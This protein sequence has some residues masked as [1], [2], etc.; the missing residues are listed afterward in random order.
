MVMTN[1]DDGGASL[2]RLFIV[3]AV[4]LALPYTGNAMAQT[5]ADLVL[6]EAQRIEDR[7]NQRQTEREERFRTDQI[8]PPSG[9]E[10]APV[11]IGTDDNGQC[12]TVKE[13]IV[14]GLTLYPQTKF[15]TST[16]RLVGDCIGI[17]QIDDA[18]RDITN[19]YISDG[20][21]TSRAV[22]SPQELKTGKL[23]I[24]V[25][26]GELSAIQSNDDGYSDLALHMAFVGQAGQ[27]LNLR[28][29]EQGVDQLSR[30]NSY[31]PSI[32]I[33][34]GV[35]PGTSKLLVMRK[36]LGRSW[37]PTI[38]I[39]DDG[40]A[41]TGRY[42]ATAGL[43]LDNIAGI[44]DYWSLY[45]TRDLQRDPAIGNVSIGGFVSVPY[46]WWTLSL[47]GGQFRY[48]SILAGN[49]QSFSNTG[50]SWNASVSLDNMLYRD[51]DS[52]VSVNWSLALLDT[53]NSIQGIRLSSS[54]YR[55]VTG[56]VNLRWQQRLENS[57]LGLDLGM[58]RG[59]SILGANSADT[60]PGGASI[61]ARRVTAAITYQTKTSAWGKPLDYSVLLRGQAALD[62]VFSNGRFGLGGSS[63][64]RGFRDDGIS[65]RYGLFLRQQ[66]GFPLTAL[67]VKQ[68]DL[69][70]V[71]SGFVGYDAGAIIPHNGDRFE[72]GQL[73]ASTV[74]IRMAS[75]FVQAELS[76][77]APFYAPK[78]IKRSPFE[79]ATSIRLSF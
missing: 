9:L 70:S 68:D 36:R 64:V 78:F 45:Y 53:E 21:V 37:R 52:K 4:A 71:F 55:Q 18:L 77:S 14:K 5:A 33:E 35:D 16:G 56:S 57:L 65:G 13:V 75:R 61:K 50:E 79:V 12:V 43:D 51:A 44:A 8:T 6:R 17:K 30:I 76:A 58:A 39:D 74:G 20:Y 27:K 3:S 26:E 7:E 32:D 25:V 41:A 24:L 73:H 47:S 66:V 38:S 54:S 49:D 59:I 31:E 60:G 1:S 23:E 34:P 28:G 15:A 69:K 2:V 42:Q 46:G 29:I 40:S 48:S 10:A 72:R 67:L 11:E 63:T 22:V 19:H 62:P